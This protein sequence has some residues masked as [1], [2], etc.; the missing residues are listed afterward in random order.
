MRNALVIVS[1][2]LLFLCDEFLAKLSRFCAPERAFET[3]ERF[4]K[5]AAR[6]IVLMMGT[7]C[8]LRLE[9][10]NRSGK[11]LPERFLLVTN[12]QSLMDIPVLIDLFQGKNLRF[13]AKKELGLGL[14]FVSDILRNQGH[15]LIKRDGDSSQAM[16]AILRFARRCEAEGSCPVI[17]PEGTRSCDGYVGTFHTAG[18]RKILAETPLPI[19]VAVM[20]GGWRVARF[21]SLL[22]NLQG[23]RFR[24]RVLS[25]TPSLSAKREVL[26]AVEAARE[27]IVRG[28]S[29]LRDEKS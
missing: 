1:I 27:E 8:G 29:A 7:Y 4:L 15:A 9:Y 23:V 19:V 25:V 17:F 21:K 11:E 18:V 13:V 22:F 12:H 6:Q 2:F 28:L 3:N 10:E 16:R 24:V 20:D 26:S 14:P 5:R